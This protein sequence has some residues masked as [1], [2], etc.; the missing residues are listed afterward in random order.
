[1]QPLFSITLKRLKNVCISTSCENP[2][3]SEKK[4]IVITTT[5]EYKERHTLIEKKSSVSNKNNN[6]AYIF[7]NII[8]FLSN[9]QSEDIT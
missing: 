3:L 5:P 4:A 9:F 1:M 7:P 8:H 2:L 6:L